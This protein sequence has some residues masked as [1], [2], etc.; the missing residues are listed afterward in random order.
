MSVIYRK[1]TF[2]K[3]IQHFYVSDLQKNYVKIGA[4]G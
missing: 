1:I 2:I 4:T 3:N